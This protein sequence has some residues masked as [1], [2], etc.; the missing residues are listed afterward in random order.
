MPILFS[1]E[2]YTE[3]GKVDVKCEF[4]GSSDPHNVFVRYFGNGWWTVVLTRWP[5]PSLLDDHANYR[6]GKWFKY[7][8]KWNGVSPDDLKLIEGLIAERKRG[9]KR[10]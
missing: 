2:E 10:S 8:Y 3:L 9:V 7:G 1:S 6:A 5:K 4:D